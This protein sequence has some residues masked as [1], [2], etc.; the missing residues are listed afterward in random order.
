MMRVKSRTAFDEASSRQA[1][2]DLCT[3]VA[4]ISPVRIEPKDG[5]GYN[6]VWQNQTD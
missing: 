6:I 4:P 5:G 1:A 3:A 2:R